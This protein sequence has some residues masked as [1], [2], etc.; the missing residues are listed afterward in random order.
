MAEFGPRKMLRMSIPIR[1]VETDGKTV[2][3]KGPCV[4]ESGYTLEVGRKA[5]SFV[6]TIRGTHRTVG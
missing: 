4:L 2:R 1:A 5:G 3:R 6:G